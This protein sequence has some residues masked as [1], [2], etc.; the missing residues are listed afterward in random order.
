MCWSYLALPIIQTPTDESTATTGEERNARRK[1]DDSEFGDDNPW[2]YFW[3]SRCA[4]SQP[5]GNKD[6]AARTIDSVMH[7]LC[8]QN[9]WDVL[10]LV[11]G[12]SASV[13]ALAIIRAMT[14]LEL[15]VKASQRLHD[16]MAEA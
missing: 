9:S 7:S 13:V 6:G 16:R 1:D 4:A 3:H 14:S 12:L 15:T 5:V 11:I 2:A 10:G 8:L